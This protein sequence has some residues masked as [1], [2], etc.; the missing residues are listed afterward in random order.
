MKYEVNFAM[1]HCEITEVELDEED[2]QGKT[3]DEIE[4]LVEEIAWQQIRQECTEY[5]AEEV[6]EI[7][8]IAEV[9]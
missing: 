6:I 3:E 7:T 9:E 4:A 1:C 8:K 2:I 5:D